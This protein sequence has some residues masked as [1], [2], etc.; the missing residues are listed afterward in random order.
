MPNHCGKAP[1]TGAAGRH[2]AGCELVV[3]DGG[4]LN[5][6]PDVDD[7]EECAGIGA[8][9]LD[10]RRWLQMLSEIGVAAA[11]AGKSVGQQ[12][13]IGGDI[14]FEE[15]PSSAPDAAGNTAMR[16]SPAKNP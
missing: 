9:A 12:M 8:L 6:A 10:Y 15:D 13:R 1:D 7:R 2:G 4:A 5:G 3:G 14:G 11:I 16:A